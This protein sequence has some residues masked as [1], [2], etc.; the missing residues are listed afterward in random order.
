VDQAKVAFLL[1]D[2]PG[3]ADPDSPEDRGGLLSQQ[4]EDDGDIGPGGFA[5]FEA[6]ANQVAND[7]PPEVWQ[8]A[9]RLLGL[10][11]DR[12]RV[13]RELVMAMVPQVVSAVADGQPYDASAHK[14]AL[15]AL[16]LPG[17]DEVIAAMTSVVRARQPVDSDELLAAT[18]EMLGVPGAQEPHRT[19]IEHVFDQAV[20]D[21]DLEFVPGELVVEPSSFCARAVLT[22]R[23]TSNERDGGYLETA[24]DLVCFEQAE[25]LNGPGGA[26]LE[27]RWFDEVGP[28]WQGPPGWLQGF[29]VGT[30]FAV[31]SSQDGNSISVEALTTGPALEDAAVTALRAAYDEWVEGLDLPISLELLV[32]ILITKDRHFFDQPIAPMRDLLA[33]AGLEHR[34]DEVAHAP[35]IWRRADELQQYRR[36][37]SRFEDA[38]EAEAAVSVVELFNEGDWDN[39]ERMREALSL[40]RDD[41]ATAEIVASELLGPELDESTEIAA[42]AA[43]AARFADRLLSFARKPPDLAVARWLMALADERSGDV[44]GAEAQLRTAVGT[45]PEW[46]PAVDRLAW[47]LS[48]RGDADEAARLWRGIGVDEDDPRLADMDAAWGAQAAR[49]GRNDP[50]WC[51]SGR[52]YKMCH[53]GTPPLPPLPERVRWLASKAVSYLKR[54]SAQAAPYILSIAAARADGDTSAEGMGRALSDP[55][56]LDLVLNEGGWFEKFLE[57]RGP[58]LPSDEALLAVSWALVDRTIFEILSVRPGAG[59]TVKDLRTAEELEVRERTFSRQAS[60]GVLVCARA[61]PDG[62][63]HQFLGGLFNVRTG[64]EAALL[65]LLDEA[66]PEAIAAWAGALDRPPVLLTR[67]SEPTVLCKAVI[68]VPDAGRARRALDDN[69]GAGEAGTWDELHNISPDEQIVRAT[70]KLEGSRLTVETNSEERMDRVLGVLKRDI[71]LLKVLADERQP[72]DLAKARRSSFLTP[73]DSAS[74]GARTDEGV[75]LPPEVREQLQEK[76]ERRWCDEQV[77]ALG[78]VTPRQAAADPTRREALARL[79]AEFERANRSRPEGAIAM[80]PARL[81]EMLGLT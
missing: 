60:P 72:L 13:M 69:Y 15:A 51:G 1:G 7:D 61:V 9:Q 75:V 53:P 22:H 36:I 33:A 80:R 32:L 62:Q 31:R 78:G 4:F 45:F 39:A 37:M 48:D 26:Q 74:A 52:K 41:T 18:A 81:R 34:D 49:P 14:A 57:D 16:P 3:W 20:E 17:V 54:Q 66:D 25:I 28:V 50:C 77:P 30:V 79:L 71:P 10:G 43:L 58:L 42:Q 65:D 68:Q 29:P 59:V 12:H 67:E 24:V 11:L 76:F 21:E 64:T 63:G 6:V 35:E 46:G 70:I 38:E 55:L 23:L 27:Y 73:V 19:L 47:Y 2:P 44:I 5:L 8:A 40:L 56:T